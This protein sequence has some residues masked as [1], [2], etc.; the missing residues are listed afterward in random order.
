MVAM[1]H[2][3]KLTGTCD[4]PKFHFSVACMSVFFGGPGYGLTHATALRQA[5]KALR[6]SSVHSSLYSRSVSQ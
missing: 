6:R 3:L 4:T 2:V 5:K 1:G